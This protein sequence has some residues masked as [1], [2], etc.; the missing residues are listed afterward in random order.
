MA[1]P[2][3]IDRGG[4][5]VYRQPFAAQGV[6]SYG[7]IIAAD[8]DALQR[9]LCD[10]YFNIPSGGKTRFRPATNHVLLA[11]SSLQALRSTTQPYSDYGWYSE[12]ETAF[13]ALVVDEASG[14]L[15]WAFP[16]IWVDN[17]LAMAMGRELYG[18]P[19]EIGWFQMPP[20]PQDIAL[21][22]TETLVLKEYSPQTQGTR[23]RIVEV[24]RVD[25]PSPH[26][27]L[28]TELVSG[29]KEI[30]AHLE[31]LDA[32]LKEIRMAFDLGDE[33]L[34]GRTPMVFLKQFRD[35]TD[36]QYAC[37]QSLV[38]VPTT[39][40][41]KAGGRLSGD[42]E[43]TINSFASHPIHQ[44]LGLQSGV[45]RPEISFWADVDF[46]IGDAAEIWKA[47]TS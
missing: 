33:M 40:Q 4:E 11:Y 43:I 27:G 12:Q 44:D 19:K 8:A 7:F 41:F 23:E 47:E 24:R 13:W 14:T 31:N 29:A 34:H 28:W 25:E 30:V 42:Y 45:L 15:Y 16:Y 17:S 2:V 22:T 32:T 10:R 6:R 18:F 35:I 39:M 37:F 1:R 36:G 20:E 26:P 46:L 5:Q 38:E 3:Y 21:L 9:N